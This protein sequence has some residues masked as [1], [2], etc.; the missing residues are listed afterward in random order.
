MRARVPAPPGPPHQRFCD[1]PPM[2]EDAL[3]A[4]LVSIWERVAGDLRAGLPASTFDL[5]LAPLRPVAA[6]GTTLCVT[7]PRS[8]RAW[9][10]RRYGSALDAALRTQ[11]CGL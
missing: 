10:E 5:W 4:D 7:A 2:P 3:H 8:S 6:Q 1:R 9:V 11:D